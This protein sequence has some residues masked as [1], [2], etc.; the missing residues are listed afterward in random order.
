MRAIS[1][2]RVVEVLGESLHSE[3]TRV[4]SETG[5]EFVL[6]Q[7]KPQYQSEE[8][9]AFLRLQIEQLGQLHLPRTVV[10]S[11][12][13]TKGGPFFLVRDFFE[14]ESLVAWSRGSGGLSSWFHVAIELAQ[15]LEEIHRAGHIHKAVKPA[16]VI[17][18]GGG[19]VL[20]LIDDVQILDINQL[21]HFIFDPNYRRNTLPYISPEQTGRIRHSLDYT[22]DLYSLGAVLYEL[23][24]GEP[25]FVSSDPLAVIHSHLAEAPVA[26]AQRSP[27]VPAMV[28]EIVL[29]L[30]QKPPEK[31]YQTAAGLIHDLKRCSRELREGKQITRF[32]LGRNDFSNR[33]TIPSI[34]VGRDAE[35]RQLLDQHARASEGAF[36]AAVVSGFSGIGKTRLIQE[37]Q[38]PIVAARGYFTSGKFDQYQKHIPYSTLIAAMRTLMRTFL[39]ED[40]ER[41]AY[42]RDRLGQ[43]LHSH[44]GLIV[45]IV[46]ELELIIGEQPPV[47]PLPPTEARNR[48]NDTIGNFIASL[49]AAEHP[50][51]LFIDDL[52]WCD[53]ATFDII[54]ILFDNAN[55]YPHLFLLGAYR[56]NEVGEGHRLRWL[57]QKVERLGRP[58]LKLHLDALSS[59]NVNDMTAYILNTMPSRTRALSEVI[60]RTSDGNPLFVNESLRWLHNHRHLHLSTD[61]VWAWDD[62]QIQHTEIPSTAL[63]LFRDKIARVSQPS[64]ELLQLAACLGASFEASTLAACLG[65]RMADLYAVLAEALS[66]NLLKKDKE[67]ISFFHDQV[68]AA[69]ESFI[70][71]EGSRRLHALIARTLIAQ[72]LPAAE[73]EQLPDLFSLVEHLALGRPEQ[74]DAAER[75][76]EAR[77]N[78][79]AGLKAMNAMAMDNANHFFR[80]ARSL[81]PT[82]SWEDDYDFLFALHKNLART[83]MATGNQRQSEAIVNTLL[84]QANNDLDKADCLYEQT[85]GLSSMGVFRNAIELGNRGLD[86][87]DRRIPDDDA[88]ALRRAAAIIDTIHRGDTDIWQAILDVVP[89]EN[90]ATKIETAI[91]SELIPDYYLA[92]MVPQLYL[93]AIQSTENCL[94]GGVDESVIYG[95]S[96]VGLYLQ[97][98]DR[99]DMS[100]RYEDLGIALAHRYPNTFGATKGING[101]LWTNMHNRSGAEHVISQCRE[102]IHRGKTCGDLY[103]AGLSYGPLIWNMIARGDDLDKVVE[104][105]DECVSFSEKFNL[106]LSLGLARSALAGWSDH[107]HVDRA[108]LAP[109]AIAD[110]LATWEQAKHVVSIGGYYTLRG[111]SSYYLGRYQ[112]SA[113]NLRDAKPYL[114]GLSDNILNRLWYVFSFVNALQL[115][116]AGA[117]VEQGEGS[118]GVDLAHC[119]E[120]VETWAQLGPILKPYLAFMNAERLIA[121]GELLP[122]RAAILEAI[123][124]CHDGGCLL[125]EGHLHER[126]GHLLVAHR[127]PYGETAFEQALRLYDA[128]GASAKASQ[129]RAAHSLPG[130]QPEVE[131][132]EPSLVRSPDVEY[133]FRA[134]RA[135]SQELDGAAVQRVIMTSIMERIGATDG[136]LFIKQGDGLVLSVRGRKE[137]GRV[138]VYT[139]QS[140]LRD[141]Q[142]SIAVVRLAARSEER[143]S[144]PDARKDGPFVHDEQ[145]QH[146]NIRSVLCQPIVHQQRQLGVLYL[147][148]TLLPD[149][150]DPKASELVRLLSTQAAIS[151]QNAELYQQLKDSQQ[152]QREMRKRLQSILDNTSAVVF[153]KDREGR[154]ML[155]NRR[156]ERLFGVGCDDLAGKTD[157]DLFPEPVARALRASDLQVLASGGVMEFEERLPQ[158]G[159]ERIYLSIKACMLD[160]RGEPYAI[161]GIATDITDRK[162]TEI[163][164]ADNERLLLKA[165]DL[166]KLGSWELQVGSGELRISR[167]FQRMVEGEGRRSLQTL[168]DLIALFSEADREP[169][170]H[171][172]AAVIEQG[173]PCQAEF[174]LVPIEALRRIFELHAELERE[175]HGRPWRVHGIVHDV[176]EMRRSEESLRQAQKMEAV[177]LLAGGVA[178][179]LNNMLVPILGYA[180]M[181]TTRL[182]AEGPSQVA[183]QRIERA[184]L[185]AKDVVQ[186]LLAFSRKQVISPKA[187]DVQHVVSDAALMLKHLIREDVRVEMSFSAEPCWAVCDSVQL[188]RVFLNLAVNAQ[189]AMPAGGRLS[190]AVMPVALER[191]GTHLQGR[192]GPNVLIQF[193]DSGSGMTPHTLARIFEPF[194]TTKLGGAG[195]GLGLSTV[196]GIVQQHEGGISVESTTGMGTTFKVYLPRVQAEGQQPAVAE[197][198]ILGFETTLRPVIWVVE[199]NELVRDVTA[200]I[201]ESGG[202]DVRV[203]DG[204]EE[205][206]RRLSDPGQKVDLLLTDVVMPEMDGATLFGRVRAL[207]PEAKVIYMSGYT[208]GVIAPR[209]VLESEAHFIQK[210]FSGKVLLQKVQSVLN[211]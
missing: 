18:A 205:C 76:E 163:A 61:G 5:R 44:G 210:P 19:S 32:A 209:G 81:F 40:A 154:Y 136:F 201:L 75:R 169:L 46:P 153:I 88:E 166:A 25:P 200:A 195:T 189:D 17:V 144:L 34:M 69:A 8:V 41:L 187:L 77:Y 131:S 47:P 110:Y 162:R 87:F 94:A 147:Q 135:I 126:L 85:A 101:I 2:Y 182:A 1:D 129:L 208:E 48:F 114:R 7:I 49:A 36:R 15:F 71:A 29:K 172:L 122:A 174:R 102:N 157:F 165:E 111:I 96:M 132:I 16:N 97:R 158:A 160:E 84:E 86:Y 202:Y 11:F 198:E 30:L 12:H 23:L 113:A 164:L 193:K 178:H 72:I 80:E 112:E 50:L 191:V 137:R 149:A 175:Q 121:A 115:G 134:S 108:P 59:A 118:D 161:C 58:L 107:M 156:F 27:V 168:E 14:G 10:P 192:A 95:F 100:F 183:A 146:F 116:G 104:V 142:L 125:L 57:L 66:Y 194:F 145:V 139:D 6:R 24:V 177:G 51:T 105:A 39:T 176:T 199:D 90:R 128:C 73:L 65:L 204:G 103:N 42:W 138:R 206:L 38:L 31:R 179:D 120:R 117:Q 196:Y 3:V 124:L 43:A 98:Q 141:A 127:R 109:E 184:A 190:I 130:E 188:E 21:S 68:Q 211:E 13:Q 150:F 167:N 173:I 79:Y 20:R 207:R 70:D 171:A 186:K 35:R 33:I 67:V 143:V 52:Q 152:T 60:Y 119:L 133:L 28:S 4:L 180:E 91:Y 93:S 74:P 159:A 56:H 151:L 22:T 92:G 203:A 53:N 170:R 140:A 185:R 82:E 26:P 9:A 148:N 78:Y 83:E 99:Y 54:E 123:D 55:E 64:I 155:V 106:S 197:A 37:L 89:S 62:D 181:L 63:D 45:D